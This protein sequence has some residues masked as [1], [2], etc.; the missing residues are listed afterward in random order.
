M[1]APTPH[2]CP[3]CGNPTKAKRLCPRCSLDSSLLS[4]S[5]GS[6]NSKLRPLMFGA[7]IVF[8]AVPPRPRAA[9]KAVLLV[10][11]VEN[12]EPDDPERARA[13]DEIV[14]RLRKGKL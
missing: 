14:E 8:D 1:T 9:S 3:C 10:K 12:V 13:V 5:N 7:G 6:A 4:R 11:Y 2:N